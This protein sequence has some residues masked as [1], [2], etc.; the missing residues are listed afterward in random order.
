MYVRTFGFKN[1]KMTGTAI[2]DKAFIIKVLVNGSEI[3]PFG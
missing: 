1:M 3:D 2:L